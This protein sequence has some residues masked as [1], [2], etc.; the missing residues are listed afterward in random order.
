MSKNKKIE[1]AIAVAAGITITA[2]TT[3]C[4]TCAYIF[5]KVF[6]RKKEPLYLSFSNALSNKLDNDKWFETV[7][8]AKEWSLNE[9]DLLLHATSIV[10][11]FETNKWVINV[12]GYGFYG[13]QIKD[14]SRAYYDRGYNCLIP[15]LRA[16][17]ESEGKYSYLGSKEKEDIL[18]WILWILKKDPNAEIVLHGT[19]IGAN[20]ILNAAGEK[21]PSNV[22]AIISDSAYSTL[23]S[24]LKFQ[25]GQYLKLPLNILIPG[26]KFLLKNKMGMNINDGDTVLKVKSNE[27]PTLFIH[28][29]NDS[30][31]PYDMVF[32]LFYAN[33][34]VKDMISYQS[35]R[36]ADAFLQQDYFTKVFE[37]I[38]RV[39][40]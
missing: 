15:D 29:E 37:F 35:S 22:V 14:V 34:G 33:S 5:S 40:S 38:N 39:N 12:H 17:G 10:N 3:Y 7:N 19:S 32:E 28:G 23:D 30:F 21:L 31:V 9:D 13:N 8:K 26:I 1:V 2:A 16:H 36:H 24:L 6:K 27:I 4:A 20:A 11:E 25:I 18:I